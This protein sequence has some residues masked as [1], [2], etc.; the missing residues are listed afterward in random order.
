VHVTVDD[1]LELIGKGDYSFVIPGPFVDV[2]PLAGTESAPGLRTSGVVWQGFS[3]RVRRLAAT[4]TVRPGVA[5][6]ALPLRIT[7]GAGRL[8]LEN[9]THATAT[10]LAAPATPSA[11]AA[12]LDNARLA[13]ARDRV[14]GAQLL[15]LS[16]PPRSERVPIVLPLEVRGV[17]RFAGGAVPVR[18]AVGAQP[19]SVSGAGELRRLELRVVV[20]TPISLLTPRHAASWRT[21]ARRGGLGNGVF[22]TRDA[23]RRLLSAAVASQF[24]AFLANPQPGGRATTSYDYRLASRA[25]RPV[26]RDEDGTSEWWLPLVVAVGALIVSAGAIMLWAHS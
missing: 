9:A 17:V 13:I 20:P 22:A 25:T 11:L 24:H 5:A 26:A 1:R 6:K 2:R 15:R 19:V 12:A 18:A 10:A 8:R 7:V 14:L 16:G 21:V 4:I 23:A 3:P